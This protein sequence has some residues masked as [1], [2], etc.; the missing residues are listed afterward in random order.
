L[1]FEVLDATQP[2][3]RDATRDVLGWR[4]DYLWVSPSIAARCAIQAE[5]Y[6]ARDDASS[7]LSFAGDPPTREATAQASDHFPVIADIWIHQ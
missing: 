1:G 3:G 5:V 2:D 4:L 6:D 7:T